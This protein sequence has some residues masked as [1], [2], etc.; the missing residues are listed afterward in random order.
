[1]SHCPHTFHGLCDECKK[2]VQV[3]VSGSSEIDQYT[4]RLKAFLQGK[5][6]ALKQIDEWRM[7][8]TSLDGLVDS[9]DLDA[10]IREIIETLTLEV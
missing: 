6:E 4:P 9:G 10:K 7:D 2:P 3:K 1:M 5:A 8:N